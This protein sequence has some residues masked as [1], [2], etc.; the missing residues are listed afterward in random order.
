MATSQTVHHPPKP[1]VI[2]AS[3]QRINHKASDF[4]DIGNWP[5]L[6]GAPI[7]LPPGTISTSQTEN[8]VSV[9]SNAINKDV[10]T[11]RI[12]SLEKK[13]VET[14]VNINNNNN[15][16]DK[17]TKA[18]GKVSKP[19]WVPLEIDVK[20]RSG[21]RDRSPRVPSNYKD[22]DSQSLNGD[23]WRGK[24]SSNRGNRY[25]RPGRGGRYSLRGRGSTHQ[26]NR[27]LPIPLITDYRHDF[28]QATTTVAAYGAKLSTGSYLMPYISSY[29]FGGN[30]VNYLN[31]DGPTLKDYIKKQIEYYFSVENLTGDFFLRRKM[32]PDGTI[33]VTLIASFHRVRALTTDL[34]L[35]LEAI[36]ESDK[37]ELI[38]GFL[39]RTLVDPTKWPILEQNS[40]IPNS[41]SEDVEGGNTLFNEERPPSTELITEHSIASISNTELSSN[42]TEAPR[43][44]V[45]ELVRRL[46]SS[47]NESTVASSPSLMA[48]SPGGASRPASRGALL[49]LFPT[50]VRSLG[51]AP[52]MLAPLSGPM[53]SIPAPPMP[54]R[55][56]P[57][58]RTTTD[59]H[60]NPDVP[61]FIPTS[62]TH[63]DILN[64]V[65]DSIVN[66]QKNADVRVS[67]KIEFKM[68]DAQITDIWT[69]VKRRSKGSS[70]EKSAPSN[71]NS[72]PVSGAP[73]EPREELD[74]Q[75][76]EE[77]DQTVPP[78]RQNT[79]TDWSDGDESD[80]EFTD[81]DVNK[82]VI[83]TQSSSR[84]LRHDGRDRG[85]SRWESR[86]KITR[87]LEQAIS[88]GLFF[89]EADIWTHTSYD[90][91]RN[92]RSSRDE[93]EVSDTP[94]VREQ[95]TP[96]PPPPPPPYYQQTEESQM[97]SSGRRKDLRKAARFYAVSKDP[98]NTDLRTGR[99]RKTRHS[100]D[101]PVEHHVGWIMDSREH[102]PR[103]QSMGS[104]LGT[105]PCESAAG[106]SWGSTGRSLPAFQHPSHSLLRENNF[107]QQLYHKY[108]SRCLKERKRL[109]IGQSQEMNTLFRFWSFF[110]RDN[111]NKNMY[112]EFK[113][114]A[115]EDAGE[116]YR[117]GL[118]CLFRFF[119]YG[120]EK[121]FR[122]HLYQD[123]QCETVHDYEKGQL[124]G[125]EKFWAFLKY[126]KH[127]ES[128]Q[129]D[130]KLE[131]YLLKFKT[132]EDFRVV[133]PQLNE[134]LSRARREAN[135]PESR[136]TPGPTRTRS[137]SESDQTCSSQADSSKL[138]MS[139]SG[140]VAARAIHGN[141]GNHSRSRTGSFG[142]G[143]RATK[144]LSKKDSDFGKQGKDSDRPHDFT[145]TKESSP[146]TV[147]KDKEKFGSK[148]LK[149]Q[150][151][152]KDSNKVHTLKENQSES[153]E[154]PKGISTDMSSKV[155]GA[156]NNQA[157]SRNKEW[158]KTEEVGGK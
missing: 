33:P 8:H 141:T 17:A 19:K 134:L 4:T 105:S 72:K 69:E 98:H 152:P 45:P 71:N 49:G 78:P 13:E 65:N 58:T 132:I 52:P 50:A 96:P 28:T 128:L 18:P 116:G 109:G 41:N 107:T 144:K 42:A 51:G 2:K 147:N 137:V 21:K 112:N 16:S 79:F 135:Q 25:N 155:Q 15:T 80:H 31:I 113:M 119:S 124:Y 55:F 59:D 127:A 22:S 26:Q 151:V 150:T 117:Y 36:R 110:L 157:G 44:R 104:S 106:S 91:S 73:N 97:Q 62:N 35:V 130:T 5:S 138:G 32:A 101:P 87:D 114:L 143:L 85:G 12:R 43:E 46:S 148:K 108:H 142:S 29:Y 84:A 64:K 75:F 14:P 99:K 125:I 149:S 123:F 67:P 131:D 68:T 20:S 121:K 102:R 122:P 10:N 94:Q 140:S 34:P 120:L 54:I 70:K 92:H 146:A 40:A 129:V 38:K 61:E 63:D 145:W 53:P 1:T 3:K 27:R 77:L 57:V 153:K 76:D 24:S 7:V 100:L 37:I 30:P 81:R 118:E 111:F 136:R 126:Y 74:F 86:V 90:R 89:Y 139:W 9:I 82:L 154:V 88:D 11:Q 48:T 95:E 156:S 39:V 103:T 158:R 23:D 60:L 115:L 93:K 56:R 47:Q 133:E 66:H 6:G 83:V